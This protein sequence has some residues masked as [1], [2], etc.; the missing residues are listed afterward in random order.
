MEVA[1]IL[2]APL[3]VVREMD[4]FDFLAILD[5]SAK[6]PDIARSFWN[7]FCKSAPPTLSLEGRERNRT[8]E[9]LRHGK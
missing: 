5:S 6:V 1:R 8:I 2:S 4:F 3:K 7:A 9:A